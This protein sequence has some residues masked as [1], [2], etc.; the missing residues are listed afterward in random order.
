MSKSNG[1]GRYVI[2]CYA[3]E[4]FCSTRSNVIRDAIVGMFQSGALKIP[5]PVWDEFS[6]AYDDEAV[7]IAAYNP[8][9]IKRKPAHRGTAGALASKANSGFR[10]EP[11]HSSDWL[12]AAVAECEGC[13]L[14]TIESK[15]GFYLNIVTCP[16]LAITDI[17]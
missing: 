1:G 11:Y 3:L 15:C 5:Q 16:V 12:A 14:I 7:A 13:T 6:D 9:R 17:Q 8:Q 2:D 10:P 4:F